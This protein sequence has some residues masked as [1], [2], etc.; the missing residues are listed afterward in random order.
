LWTGFV[1]G[2]ARLILELSKASLPSGT[3]WSWIAGINFLH[4]AALLFLLCSAI[5]VGV[6]LLTPA[7]AP[8]RVADLTLQTATTV[9]DT[10]DTPKERRLTISLSVLL[11]VTIGVLW[12]VFR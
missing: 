6:S 12:F 9:L 4:F 11:A 3:V 10:Q 2:M 8:E 7:P 1:I 5:L